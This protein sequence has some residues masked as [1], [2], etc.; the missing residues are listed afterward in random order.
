M[1]ISVSAV[2]EMIT[3]ERKK[4]LGNECK[5]LSIIIAEPFFE[6]LMEEHNF[7]NKSGIRTIHLNIYDIRLEVNK[8]E[9][10]GVGDKEFYLV[11]LGRPYFANPETIKK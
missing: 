7:R 10:N 1:Y 11:L 3:F 2:L 8:A 9:N 5:E 6:A 4:Y